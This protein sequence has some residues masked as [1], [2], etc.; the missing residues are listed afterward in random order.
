MKAAVCCH[1][2]AD[3]LGVCGQ[4]HFC[5]VI[6]CFAPSRAT[7]VLRNPSQD[8]LVSAQLGDRDGDAVIS[9]P[10]FSSASTQLVSLLP[11]SICLS[12]YLPL[13]Q[14]KGITEGAKCHGTGSERGEKEGREIGVGGG[15]R[16]RE[17]V[18]LALLVTLLLWL[19]S[20]SLPKAAASQAI[21]P[22]LGS[23][24]TGGAP[25]APQAVQQCFIG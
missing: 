23:D 9:R 13:S 4:W 2:T 16:K 19:L 17:V 25:L 14:R 18:Y 5:H 10:D 8:T 20:S 1:Q 15:Q 11:L 21:V 24:W 3:Q 12:L 22:N 7:G 6:C